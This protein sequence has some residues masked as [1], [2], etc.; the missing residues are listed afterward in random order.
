MAISASRR[1]DRNRFFGVKGVQASRLRQGRSAL[2]RR[3]Q[4]PPT[5]LGGSLVLSHRR[6]G[7]PSCRCAEGLGHPLWTL[8]YSV[9]GEKHVDNIPKDLVD[10]LT[11]FVEEG[12]A[13]R[14]AVAEIRA[15]NAQ[16]LRLWQV[17][18]RA[19]KARVA[20]KQKKRA[21]RTARR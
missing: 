3:F 11:T 6:C 20:R 12:Q 2:A 10:E 14:E 16:L 15:L 8:T 19:R 21:P 18:Q 13:Y 1:P 9:D 7:K 5:L 17:D 4:L